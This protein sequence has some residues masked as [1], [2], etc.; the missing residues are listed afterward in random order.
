MQA[1]AALQDYYRLG[2]GRSLRA[3]FDKYRNRNGADAGLKPP[4][5][6]DSTLRQWSADLAWQA[7]VDAQAE[8]DRVAE[9]AAK[10][11]AL[12]EEA[13]K[14]AARRIEVRDR[15]W[16]QAERLR[17]LADKI[18]AEAPKFTK[19]SRKLI[20]GRDGE[21]D[22][23]II[24]IGIDAQTMIKATEAASK[25]QRLAAEMETEH[26]LEERTDAMSID[27]VRRQRWADAQ[28]A[29]AEALS[30]GDDPSAETNA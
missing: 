6:R 7:R 10:A 11:A 25:L 28:S 15:D 2:P 4:T 29:L 18:M 14:W 5:R 30:S 8:L 13:A 12:A 9:A 1:N 17:E 27:E 20:K 21:P 22:R 3:L 24:T 26:T 16:S 23:E 19:T